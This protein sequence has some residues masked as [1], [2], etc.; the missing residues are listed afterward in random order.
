M[1][2]SNGSRRPLCTCSTSS[3]PGGPSGREPCSPAEFADGSR[4]GTAP[5]RTPSAPLAG[6]PTCGS[7]GSETSR[8]ISGD[9]PAGRWL[10]VFAKIITDGDSP[11]PL[12]PQKHAFER[13]NRTYGDSAPNP[14]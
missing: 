7:A 13:Q 3:E 6:G 11:K 9:T 12:V 2:V 5:A 8:S 10:A 4:A 14:L 1:S